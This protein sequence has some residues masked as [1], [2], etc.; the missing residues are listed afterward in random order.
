MVWRGFGFE[1]FLHLKP[2]FHPP[3]AE[4]VG[5]RRPFWGSLAEQLPGLDPASHEPAF[6][7][8]W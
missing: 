7:W 1:S 2:W 6:I 3:Q 8:V 5:E 4:A